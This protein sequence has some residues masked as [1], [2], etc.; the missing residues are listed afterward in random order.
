[1]CP[2]RKLKHGAHFGSIAVAFRPGLR[3]SDGVDFR[4]RFPFGDGLSGSDVEGRR[5]SLLIRGEEK[6]QA[7]SGVRCHSSHI[8]LPPDGDEHLC[9]VQQ[10][11]LSIPRLDSLRRHMHASPSG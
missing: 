6:G 8:P 11:I 2:W 10:G 4:A 5:W 7:V 9:I 1:M 3:L